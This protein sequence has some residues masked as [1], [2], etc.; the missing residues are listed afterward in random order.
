VLNTM[1]AKGPTRERAEFRKP[2]SPDRR[3][4][5]AMMSGLNAVPESELRSELFR[6]CGS[7]QWV[8]QML[9]ARPYESILHLR[10]AADRAWWSL[11]A[12]EWRFAFLSHPR[13]GDVD[14]L[15]EKYKKNPGAWEGGEQSGAD[16]AAEATI[17]ALKRGNDEYFEKFGHIFL[18]CATGKSAEEMLAALRERY[19]NSPEAELLI[20]TGEQAK[21]THL[22]LTKL[23]AEKTRSSL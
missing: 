19:P 21:I 3:L 13:I 16:N 5:F 15:K 17:Q 1:W 23:L 4:R 9:C 20:A 7:H 2:L 8:E 6:C 22:R 14:A 11:P 12:A 10:A 18:I